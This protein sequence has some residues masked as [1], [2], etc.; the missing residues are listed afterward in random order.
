[1]NNALIIIIMR[2]FSLVFLI[3]GCFLGAGFISGK[4]VAA[5]FSIFGK[6]SICGVIVLAI[7][8]FLLLI[9]FLN[10]SNKVDSFK[11]F[12]KVYFGNRAELLNFL[13]AFTMLIFIGSMMA[14]NYVLAESFKINKFVLILITL[15]L[16][17]IFVNGKAKMLSAINSILMPIIICVLLYLSFSLEWGVGND[18]SLPIALFSAVNY[19]LIN[20][21]PLGI[22]II[23]IKGDRGLSKKEIF[24]VSLIVSVIVM[25]LLFVYNNS[26]ILNDLVYSSMPILELAKGSGKILEV[27]TSVSLYLGMLTTLISCVFVLANYINGYLKNYKHSTMLSLFLGLIVSFFGFNTIVNYV[28]ALIGLIGLYVVLSV[29]IK[30]KRNL[31]KSKFPFN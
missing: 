24:L 31:K 4:E 13:F 28:Y 27:L 17:Y 10:L 18:S 11:S 20:I 8:I 9:F 2:V 30:E 25:L 3:L 19:G 5:Y 1:M 26:I 6:Y 16:A 15:V 22:F 29:I 7:L 12:V 21:V 14:G 23:D